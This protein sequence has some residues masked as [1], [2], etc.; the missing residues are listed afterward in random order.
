MYILKLEEMCRV[1]SSTLPHLEQQNEKDKETEGSKQMNR[2]GKKGRGHRTKWPGAGYSKVCLTS[3]TFFSTSL[4]WIRI[5]RKPYGEDF[6]H[7]HINIFSPLCFLNE[8]WTV[9]KLT[10]HEQRN[11]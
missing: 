6:P 4:I 8:I 3:G 11:K 2:Y 10:N 9:V 1:L 7:T 5:Q